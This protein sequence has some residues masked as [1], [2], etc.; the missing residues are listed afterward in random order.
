M[1]TP[2]YSLELF[3]GETVF[4]FIPMLRKDACVPITIRGIE[5]GGI[6]IENEQISVGARRSPEDKFEEL[7]NLPPTVAF[8][9]WAQ[10]AYI[11]AGDARGFRKSQLLHFSPKASAGAPPP[12]QGE[13]SSSG[14]VS[15]E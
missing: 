8:I 3:I 6:W 1:E 9:P 13:E 7:E 12:A 5:A 15:S 4:G 14:K 2:R 11:L 10:I